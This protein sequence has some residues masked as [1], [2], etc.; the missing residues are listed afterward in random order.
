M[1]HSTEDA[2]DIFAV[3][4]RVGW[5][6]GRSKAGPA[7]SARSSPSARGVGKRAGAR[8]L[9]DRLA[10]EVHFS[11]YF[12][13]SRPLFHWFW[14]SR[15]VAFEAAIPLAQYVQ[16]SPWMSRDTEPNLCLGQC[17][18]TYLK[19]PSSSC[20]SFHACLSYTHISQDSYGEDPEPYALPKLNP[21]P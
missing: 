16:E 9:P 11:A 1:P 20:P 21:E 8:D 12:C 14:E 3:R 5:Q 15:L 10:G 7:L 13:F 4:W 18:C 17:R 6:D 19:S 2:S